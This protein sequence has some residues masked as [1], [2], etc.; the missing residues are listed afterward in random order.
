[1]SARRAE[2]NA[3]NA[4]EKVTQTYMDTK[5]KNCPKCNVPGEKDSGCDHMTCELGHRAHVYL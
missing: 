3:R 4:I 1:M 5:T 2:E